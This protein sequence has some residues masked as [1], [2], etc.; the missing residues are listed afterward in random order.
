MRKMSL[1]PT[2]PSAK[3]FLLTEDNLSNYVDYN[4]LMRERHSIAGN[5]ISRDPRGSISMYPE[6]GEPDLIQVSKTL[7]A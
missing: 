5:L 6:P 7:E 1:E 3:K 4:A 2:I